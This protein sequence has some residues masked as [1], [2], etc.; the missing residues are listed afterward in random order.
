M[1]VCQC[2]S[3]EWAVGVGVGGNT[4]TLSIASASATY[5]NYYA[6]NKERGRWMGTG[7]GNGNGDRDWVWVWD[8]DSK[9][10]S[11]DA[12][13]WVGKRWMGMNEYR[14]ERD[15]KLISWGK[16]GAWNFF[17]FFFLINQTFL[18]SHVLHTTLHRIV[19]IPPFSLRLI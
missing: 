2:D 13:R 6:S 15:G 4:S 11:M 10:I 14:I 16:K 7:N 17:F 8:R 12:M 1:P 5:Y 19:T 3:G 18:Y 9:K